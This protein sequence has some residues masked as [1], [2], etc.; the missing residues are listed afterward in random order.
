MPVICGTPGELTRKWNG[1]R[2]TRCVARR[3]IRAAQDVVRRGPPCSAANP[4]R[5]GAGE[6]GTPRSARDCLVGADAPGPAASV[7]DLRSQS[8]V[9]SQQ[10]VRCTRS[11]LLYPGSI[12]TLSAGF[13]D[14]YRPTLHWGIQTKSPLEECPRWALVLN[15]IQFSPTR[16][17]KLGHL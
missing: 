17:R 2:S 3:G 11:V 14:P 9:H 4:R 1:D 10:G 7:S 6:T 8:G 16:E 5:G 12:S 15:W 13:G